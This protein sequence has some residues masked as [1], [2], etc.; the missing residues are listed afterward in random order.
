M[1]LANSFGKILQF[2]FQQTLPIR[3]D[4][5]SVQQF[6]VQQ[7][8]VYSSVV[9]AFTPS[10]LRPAWGDLKSHAFPLGDSLADFAGQYRIAWPLCLTQPSHLVQ[11]HLSYRLLTGVN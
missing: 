7:K 3:L 6:A 5:E 8:T 2:K 9:T 4:S 11:M 1:R 10:L